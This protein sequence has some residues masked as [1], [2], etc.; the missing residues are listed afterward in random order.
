[1]KPSWSVR[2][3]LII[4]VLTF[5]AFCITYVMVW[6]DDR[7]VH[8]MI[9]ISAFGTAASVLGSYVFGAVWDDANVMKRLS[10]RQPRTPTQEEQEEEPPDERI[11]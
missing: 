3:R 7:S 11:G 4:A 10:H 1:M 9:I 6:G 8:E 5:C 2:R